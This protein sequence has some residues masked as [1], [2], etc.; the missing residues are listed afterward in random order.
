MYPKV[1]NRRID[2]ARGL[3]NHAAEQYTPTNLNTIWPALIFAA[4]RNDK[5]I[6]RT[7]ILVVSISTKNGFN[8]LGA[9]S[10]RKWATD[11]FGDLE[12][13]DRI[14]LNHSGSPNLRVKIR[15]LVVL[16]I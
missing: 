8:Q 1:T 13:L 6:G 12:N 7:K 15:W 3:L 14:I 9:P 16:N 2:V 11:A 5:V 10:G 4:S